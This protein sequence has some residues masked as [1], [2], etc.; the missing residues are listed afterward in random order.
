MKELLITLLALASLFLANAVSP[1]SAA[2]ANPNALLHGE[3]AVVSPRVCSVASAGS[4]DVFDDPPGLLLLQ[5]ARTKIRIRR[6]IY[7]YNGDGTG[8]VEKGRSI[9]FATGSSNP[10]G[11]PI[12]QN[13]STCDLTYTVNP[14]YTFTQQTSN[15]ISIRVAGHVVGE[16]FTG[17]GSVSHGRITMGGKM[18]LFEDTDINVEY[19]T[20]DVRGD[21][22]RICGRSGTAAMTAQSPV[23]LFVSRFYQHCL[24]RM[25]DPAG[26]DSWVDLLLAGS[27]TGAD[28][29]WGFVFSQEFIDQNTTNE[30]FITILY[31][32]FFDRPSD[33]Q[34]FNYWMDLFA[35]GATREDVLDGFISA[36]EFMNLCDAYGI[37]PF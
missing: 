6:G 1:A 29:A 2:G 35:S 9:S 15:C 23:K 18:L 11:S 7:R 24:G 21:Y 12:R 30:E 20:S 33:T 31:L 19:L 34:G 14:D 10:G 4:G 26:L 16:Q 13:E 17:S 28:V 5:N 36:Q 3:Y 27:Q 22:Q 37:T 25:P 8:T 32:A